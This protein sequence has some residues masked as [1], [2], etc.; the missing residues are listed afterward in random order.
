MVPC[1]LYYYYN[2]YYYYYH[3]L[4]AS[5]AEQSKYIFVMSVCLSVCAKTEKLPLS[6]VDASYYEY[7]TVNHRSGCN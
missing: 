6:E 4:S 1:K 2:C 3:Y 5:S 7:V